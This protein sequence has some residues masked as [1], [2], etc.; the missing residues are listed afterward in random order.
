MKY[1]SQPLQLT[2]RDEAILQ[3]VYA[4]HGCMV[5]HIHDRFFRPG[6][7]LSACYRRLSRLVGEGY[8]TLYRLPSTS[9]Q[10]SGKVLLQL[11]KKG[12]HIVAMQQ[13]I[14]LTSMPR[15]PDACAPLFAL[16]H[17]A[18]C[19]FRVALEL[20]AESFPA[21]SLVEWVNEAAL[22]RRPMKV[23]DSVLSAN[24]SARTITLIPDGGFAISYWG[25]VEQGFLE[26]DMGTLALKRLQLKLR[27]YLLYQKEIRV[28]VF[29]VV[30]DNKR[31]TDVL[32]LAAVEATKIGAD[33]NVFFVTTSGGVR[34]EHILTSRVWQQPGS[35]R[36]V[37]I[38]PGIEEAMYE[39]A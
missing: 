38:L 19:S 12:R 16:H 30:P 28:P 22:K 14:T 23:K 15:R 36:P 2:P 20:A 26:M 4:Y 8:L 34:P 10:G 5:T 6:S 31:A 17:E 37:A 29:F 32:R 11:G 35:K 25:Q 27:G 1:V 18:I 3:M 9:G 7:P 33:P 39:S 21:V 13:G 24:Q